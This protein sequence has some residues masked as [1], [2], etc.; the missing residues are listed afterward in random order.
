MGR[1][2]A[3]EL[4]ERMRASKAGWGAGDLEKLYLGFGFVFREGSRH[5]L[6]VHPRYSDLYATV[7]RHRSLAIGY[8]TTAIRL[9]GE[10]KERDEHHE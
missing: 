2:E 1:S 3:E 7:G 4:L 5:R 8:I 6:Y 9:I 10:L